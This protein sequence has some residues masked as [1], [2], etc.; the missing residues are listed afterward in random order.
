MTEQ[1]GPGESQE[2]K[3]PG[4]HSVATRSDRLRGSL[5]SCISA[6]LRQTLK[7]GTISASAVDGVAHQW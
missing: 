5:A 1:A 2:N 6:G 7:L 4:A 3:I